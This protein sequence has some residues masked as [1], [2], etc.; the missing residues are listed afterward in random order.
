MV[1]AV[2]KKTSIW[3]AQGMRHPA[4]AQSEYTRPFG[5]AFG[6]YSS[7]ESCPTAEVGRMLRSRI[8]LCRGP[9]TFPGQRWWPSAHC[10]MI[11]KPALFPCLPSLTGQLPKQSL[12]RAKVQSSFA[13]GGSSWSLALPAVSPL[14]LKCLGWSASISLSSSPLSLPALRP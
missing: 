3:R 12:R 6:L 9:H 7:L 5:E 10:L 13:A 2:W 11:S 8:I 4:L 1:L 14:P